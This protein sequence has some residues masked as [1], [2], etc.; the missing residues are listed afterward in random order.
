MRVC[1]C[2]CG[3][4]GGARLCAPYC[5]PALLGAVRSWSARS[6]VKLEAWRNG[7]PLTERASVTHTT[8]YT[9]AI[10]TA[11]KTSSGMVIAPCTVKSR[12]HVLDADENRNGEGGAHTHTH[13]HTEEGGG[14]KRERRERGISRTTFTNA[15]T[16]VCQV[17]YT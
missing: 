9:R 13:T 3:G 2:V 1:A 8:L 11:L 15:V 12:S 6:R 17:M 5:T 14:A 10:S 7:R 16:T 4:G